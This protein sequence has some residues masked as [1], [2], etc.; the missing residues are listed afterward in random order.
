[1]YYTFLLKLL[2]F[3]C[4]IKKCTNRAINIHRVPAS[5]R[6]CEGGMWRVWPSPSWLWLEGARHVT[7]VC[8]YLCYPR[9]SVTTHIHINTRY[10][11][12]P[13]NTCYHTHA[14][15]SNMPVTVHTCYP[16]I[17]VIWHTHSRA[18]THTLTYAHT[19]KMSSS[20]A[21]HHAHILIYLPSKQHVKI[22]HWPA[23]DL[24]DLDDVSRVRHLVA[25]TRACS[26]VHIPDPSHIQYS[27]ANKIQL[28]LYW[29]ESMVL[30]DT[31]CEVIWWRHYLLYT[32]LSVAK[33]TLCLNNANDTQAGKFHL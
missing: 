7:G 8:T 27:I 4:L 24:C 21:W 6:Q 15:P 18:H 29:V 13:P 28:Y 30:A 32:H 23:L 12:Y 26:K 10:P 3:W 19:H 25:D 31:M 22:T 20:Y 16:R 9:I 14:L 11:C 33:A 17:P 1:M 5:C 2:I